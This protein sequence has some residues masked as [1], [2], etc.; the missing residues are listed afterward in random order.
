MRR[1]LDPEKADEIET[2]FHRLAE[3]WKSETAPLSS[4][5]L[6]KQ[7]PAYRQLVEI[8]DAGHP[9]DPRRSRPP[10]ITPVLGPARYHQRQSRGSERRQGFPGCHLVLDRM[11]TG[12]GARRVRADID[13][14]YP[15]LADVGYEITS[16]ET[17]IYN[18]LA[19]AA[20][21]T[22]RWW[23][24]GEDRPIDEPG[25]DWPEGAGCGFGLEAL[26]SAYEVIG[27]E[28][29]PEGGPDPEVGYDK[30]ALYVDNGEWRHAAKLLKD[31]VGP[32]SWA[33]W[34]M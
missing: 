32:A 34:K 25:L 13:R 30:V 19:W 4:I 11:G 7:H 22:T 12:P 18:C 23:E 6:K 17:P 15:Q 8:G 27:Y 24:C 3:E 28:L 33:T 14:H 10:A 5:R 2:S 26:I 31:G 9:P 20:G 16:E 1:T 21:D 29:C